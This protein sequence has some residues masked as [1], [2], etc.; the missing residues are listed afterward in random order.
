MRSEYRSV[1]GLL[2]LLG[3]GTWLA[4][5]IRAAEQTLDNLTRVENAKVDVLFVAP[6]VSLA[7]YREVMLDPVEVAFKADWH[8]KHPEVT[9]EDVARLRGQFSATFHDAFVQELQRNGGYPIVNEPGPDVLRLRASIVDLD[10]SAPDTRSPGAPPTR[11]VISPG[12][13]TLLAELRDSESGALLARAADRQRGRQ[14]G[15]LQVATGATN[16]AA[17]QR[18][19]KFWAGLLR[20]A[21]DA[22]RQSKATP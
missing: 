17:A 16:A 1:G 2:F 11:Y 21:L 8:E 6:G 18:A 20:Q 10:I 9:R 3:L 7:K 12:E 5:P 19:F 13:M 15:E 14:S 4:V 22:A